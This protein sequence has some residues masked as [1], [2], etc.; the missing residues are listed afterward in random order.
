MVFRVETPQVGRKT[1]HPQ[2]HKQARPPSTP[3]ATSSKHSLA[4]QYPSVTS[5]T[6]SRRVGLN[7]EAVLH[8][9]GHYNDKFNNSF[10]R[11]T[12][13]DCL[14]PVLQSDAARGGPVA[15]IITAC[16]L[17]TLGTMTGTPDL[18]TAARVRQTKVLRQLQK[19]LQDPNTAL[20]NSS[21]LTCLSL[22]SFEVCRACC[23]VC[24]RLT[25]RSDRVL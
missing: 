21:V 23:A 5:Q 9:L 2:K 20:T 14:T 17:A 24:F 16:G 8:Y 1:K 12:A 4:L 13:V 6:P 3:T 22:A 7:D 15:D 25:Y 11:T 19:Q 18:M 10:G